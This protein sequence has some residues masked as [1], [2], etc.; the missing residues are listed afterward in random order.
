MH[1]HNTVNFL[2]IFY[3]RLKPDP[4]IT[5]LNNSTWEFNFFQVV[6]NLKHS[7]VRKFEIRCTNEANIERLM[8]FIE[9]KGKKSSSLFG[10][11]NNVLMCFHNIRFQ[12]CY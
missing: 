4:F 5:D 3:G 11:C 8:V 7:V 10:H 2:E 12:I 1:V 9:T 6:V